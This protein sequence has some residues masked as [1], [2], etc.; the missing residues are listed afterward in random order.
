MR[1]LSQDAPAVRRAIEQIAQLTSVDPIV[2]LEGASNL[3]REKWDW[4]LP[5]DLLKKSYASRFLDFEGAVEIA[6]EILK[7]N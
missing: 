5:S 4:C 1:V 2:A 3:E 6:K 7:T